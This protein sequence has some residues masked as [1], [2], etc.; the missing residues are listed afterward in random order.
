MATH[1]EFFIGLS[2]TEKMKKMEKMF[3]S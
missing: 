3:G 1:E 2:G